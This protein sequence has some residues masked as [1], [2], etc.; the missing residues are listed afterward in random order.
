MRVHGGAQVDA[1]WTMLDRPAELP[2]GAPFER[3]RPASAAAS[4]A[5]EEA[6]ASSLGAVLSI[7]RRRRFT[8]ILSSLLM[9][10]LAWIALGQ[11]TP[12]Y[13]ATASVLY[14]PNTYTLPELQ[15]ILRADP[16]TEAVMASQ[17]EIVRGLRTAERVAERFGLDRDP[18]F[19]RALRP[20]GLPARLL[21]DARRT[22][23]RYLP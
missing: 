7:L 23:A 10:L 17:A 8:L 4:L 15:S 16:T 21:E 13:T 5:G 20:P 12:R 18:A 11:V 3:R 6:G 2:T 14:E 1:G 9:P 19:N 22:V